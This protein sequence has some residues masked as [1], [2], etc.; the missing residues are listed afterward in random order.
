MH[1]CKYPNCNKTLYPLTDNNFCL[2]LGS[3]KNK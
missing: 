2:L 1:I 3:S